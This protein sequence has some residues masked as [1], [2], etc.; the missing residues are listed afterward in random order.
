MQEIIITLKIQ[1][2][3][4]LHLETLSARFYPFFSAG[5]YSTMPSKNRTK[6]FLFL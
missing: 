2:Q 6:P 3:Q 4:A 5:S 1:K